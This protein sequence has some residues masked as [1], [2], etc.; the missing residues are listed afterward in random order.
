M[1]MTQDN[2]RSQPLSLRYKQS[3]LLKSHYIRGKTKYNYIQKA[4]L[5]LLS[6]PLIGLIV[7]IARIGWYALSFLLT[8]IGRKQGA[9][10]QQIGRT[11]ITA[12][13][14]ETLPPPVVPR[15]EQE[16]QEHFLEMASHELKTPMT[17]ISGQAQLLLRRLSRMPELS[18]ELVTMRTALESIDTQTHRMNNLINDLLDLYTIRAGKIQ[19]RLTTFDLIEMCHE[20]V[21]EQSL[22][23]SN[24]IELEAPQHPII[25][26][27]DSDRLGQVVVNLISNARAYSPAGSPIKVLVDQNRDIGIIEVI[28]SGSGIPVDQQ[29]HIFEPFYRGAHAQ[30]NVKSGLGLGL[31]IC[32]DIVERHAGRIWCRSGLGKGSTFFVE[33]PLNMHMV[34]RL[35]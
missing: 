2:R 20:I 9:Q 11:R 22:L 16:L 6:I 26:R 23:T 29:S 27:A 13:G 33:L 4:I 3:E 1:Q 35:H 15:Q 7:K 12:S 32:K 18:T 30:S 19:L 34:E 21:E 25:L 24:M 5:Y 17:T 8:I 31:A 10:Q 28:D 14:Q